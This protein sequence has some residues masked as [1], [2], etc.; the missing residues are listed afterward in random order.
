MQEWNAASQKHTGSDGAATC[1]RGRTRGRPPVMS[2]EDRVERILDALDAVFDRAG[3]EGTTMDAIA[4]EAGMSKRTLYGAFADR[5]ELFGA[6]MERMRRG[7]MHELDEQDLRAPLEHRL[8]RL[9]APCPRTPP[10]GLPLALL[11]LALTGTGSEPRSASSCLSGWLR[12]DRD[13]IQAELDRAVTRGEARV[14]DTGAA[15]RILEGMVRPSLFDLLLRP[16][17]APDE[18]AIR[19]R[20]ELGLAMFLVAVAA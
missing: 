9:L 7:F 12:H 5:D 10:S 13:L 19:A 2:A 3:L 16:A 14:A 8:R 15:A 18:A 4:A 1:G 17:A 6:Y 11:R 20:F